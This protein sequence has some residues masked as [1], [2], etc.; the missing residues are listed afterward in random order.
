M[1]STPLTEK[2]LILHQHN[3][4]DPIRNPRIEPEARRAFRKALKKARLQSA[5][6]FQF[7]DNRITIGNGSDKPGE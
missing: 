4:G 2:R 3:F 7:S 1:D 6:R 5:A